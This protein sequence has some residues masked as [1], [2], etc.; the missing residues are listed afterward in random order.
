MSQDP[1]LLTVNLFWSPSLKQEGFTG[2][3]LSVTTENQLGKFDILPQH[4]NFV[5]QIFKSLT[6]VTIDKKEH[7]YKFERGVLEVSTDLVR[8]FIGI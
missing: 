6:I 5:T 2:K 3:A 8:I 4:A 1:P 7:S